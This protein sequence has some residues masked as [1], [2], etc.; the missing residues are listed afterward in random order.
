MA[1][2]SM[3]DADTVHALL[4]MA[5]A[6]SVLADG[7]RNGMAGA[8]PARTSVP[9]RNG[10]LLVMPSQSDAWAGV[11]LVTVGE[12]PAGS[13]VP[14]IQ[15]TY[16]LF[17]AESL[18][19]RAII[20]AVALTNLR[21]AAMSGVASAALASPAAASLV[22][23]GTG[24]QAHWHAVA[25]TCVRP[26]ERIFVV[27]RD[28][29]KAQRFSA[30]L[31]AELGIPVMPRDASAVAD[32]DIVCTCTTASTPLFDGALLPDTAHVNAIGTHHPDAR[33]VDSTV[34]AR[35]T[36]VVENEHVARR[37]AG[38]LVIPWQEN[39]VTDAVFGR[40][41]GAVLRGEVTVP[42]GPTLFKSVGMAAEDLCVAAA[43]AERA[44]ARQSG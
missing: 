22:I 3:I 19:P 4:P 35:C 44:R 25:M 26:I 29:S 15:G 10:E 38:D 1:P 33:E 7:F 14:R 16:V 32:A 34:V 11:K 20:D 13:S 18:T 8:D 42:R 39:A 23:F 12:R 17:D 41:L 30:S 9:W 31:A 21:T 43:I 24:P 36:V 27:G 2:L 5:D 6:V 37:E 28:A 40:D